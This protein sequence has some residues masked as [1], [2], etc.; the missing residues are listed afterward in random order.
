MLLQLLNP[1]SS[2][3]GLNLGHEVT[4]TSERERRL[5]LQFMS[6]KE[7][8]KGFYQEKRSDV[9][10][11]QHFLKFFPVNK[12]RTELFDVMPCSVKSSVCLRVFSEL[13]LF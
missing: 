5:A 11:L 4:V 8:V 2:A 3:A 1:P 10:R 9:F 13:L 7:E 6:L 12:Q